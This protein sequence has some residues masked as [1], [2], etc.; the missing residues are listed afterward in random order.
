[1]SSNTYVHNIE[2]YKTFKHSNIKRNRMANA[3]CRM[4]NSEHTVMKT[5]KKSLTVNSNCIQLTFDINVFLFT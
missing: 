4:V 2:A 5:M 1:M 3:E